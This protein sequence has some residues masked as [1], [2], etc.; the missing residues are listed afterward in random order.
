MYPRTLPGRVLIFFLCIWGVFMV[1]LMVVALTSKVILSN[2]ELKALTLFLRLESRENRDKA[3]ARVIICLF[4]YHLSN[5]RGSNYGGPEQS[6]KY[7]RKLILSVENMRK[8]R[9]VMERYIDT[10]FNQ[11]DLI[12]ILDG[13]HID[14]RNLKNT[15]EKIIKKNQDLATALDKYALANHDL[16]LSKYN[17]ERKYYTLSDD[18]DMRSKYKE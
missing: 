6:R 7:L 5:K 12:N 16:D 10:K 8:A 11:D 2:A 1:S 17:G 4:K 9:K 13:L 3:A 14:L 15:Q 18:E